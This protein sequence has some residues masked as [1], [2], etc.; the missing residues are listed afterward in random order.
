MLVQKFLPAGTKPPVSDYQTANKTTV[1][2]T[3]KLNSGSSAI[4][5]AEI[6]DIISY[7]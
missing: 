6:V 7:Y 4:T 5:L 3:S 2:M 1:G